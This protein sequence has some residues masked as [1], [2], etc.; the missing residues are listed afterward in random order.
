MRLEKC[1]FLD[2]NISVIGEIGMLGLTRLYGQ[3]KQ[4]LFW[5][6]A[7][8]KR[9]EK[10]PG[11]ILIA[12]TLFVVGGVE[13]R[14]L[15]Y[16]TLWNRKGYRVYFGAREGNG[17][18][19]IRLTKKKKYNDW[20]LFL[21]CWLHKVKL[22]EWNA[23]GAILPRYSFE[24]LRERKIKVGVIIHASH[25]SWNFGYLSKAD[26][27]FC[28]HLAHGLRVPNLKQYPVLPNGI[29]PNKFRWS[30]VGQKKALLISRLDKDKLSSI[31]S[32][33]QF[34]YSTDISFQIAGDFSTCEGKQIKK[35]LQFKYSITDSV[36]IGIVDTTEFLIH[37]W[38]EILFV[39]G[40]GQVI[41]EA[42]QLDFPCL[43][44]SLLGKEYSFFVTHH[45][46]ES[47]INYNCSPH[48]VEENK[49]LQGN[50][51]IEQ[52]LKN[53]KTG[54]VSAFKLSDFIEKRCNLKNI[55]KCYNVHLCL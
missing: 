21:F 3:I 13:K 19:D 38:K 52:E 53:L 9:Q 6:A 51:N 14:F 43:L 37:S 12:E 4:I 22:V 20:L 54:K 23:G 29:I 36:F 35:Y 31:E 17:K 45:N 41:L 28:S 26:Y 16:S 24:K 7:Y 39:G 44:C 15:Q 50:Q 46:I 42:G 34:C 30:F 2:Q 25:P 1:L 40:L 32:F 10:R 5:I 47:V 33:I 8:L 55:L 27:V 49:L 18:I 48:S 11:V